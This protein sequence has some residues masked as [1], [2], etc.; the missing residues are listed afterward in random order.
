VINIKT[1]PNFTYRCDKKKDI[2]KWGKWSVDDSKSTGR[3]ER[4]S[5]AL[6]AIGLSSA[7][8][9]LRV[10]IGL[11][12]GF[13]SGHAVAQLVE[14]L[15]YNPEGSGF[16]SRWCHW[17][18]SLREFFRPHYGPGIESASNRNEYQEYFVGGK[19]GRCVGLANLSPSCVECLDIWEPQSSA[20]LRACPGL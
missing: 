7:R 16:D 2:L 1:K 8:H 12:N 15:R 10:I 19:G 18:F 4:R 6:C 17:N 3:F 14:T 13:I 20:T 9:L 11:F 5:K